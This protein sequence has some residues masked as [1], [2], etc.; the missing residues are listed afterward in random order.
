MLRLQ[1]EVVVV[2][3]AQQLDDGATAH[4]VVEA[5]PDLRAKP[6]VTGALSPDAAPK[7]A[8]DTILTIGGP[9]VRDTP[10]T[11][12]GFEPPNVPGGS[13]R[14]LAAAGAVVITAALGGLIFAGTLGG[15]PP[16][17]VAPET[18]QAPVIA[19]A[20]APAVVAPPVAAPPAEARV[21]VPE[22][23]PPARPARAR[24]PKRATG[25]KEVVAQERKAE[26]EKRVEKAKDDKK[27]KKRRWFNP[28][29]W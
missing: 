23:S 16:T 11:I 21:V 18:T 10:A 13:R 6:I 4:V 5:V 24:E 28:F 12:P 29:S 17:P 3:R 19:P 22:P 2:A 27:K 26:P 20:T 14:P 15:D 1:D 7:S 8:E 9:V 25:S